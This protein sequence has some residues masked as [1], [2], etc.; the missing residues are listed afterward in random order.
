MDTSRALPAMSPGARR[1]SGARGADRASIGLFVV[2]AYGLSWAWLVPLALTGREVAAGSGWPTQVPALFGPMVAAFVASSR[3][4][5]RAAVGDLVRRMLRTRVPSR[6][7]VFAISPLLLL[8]VVLL[9]EGVSGH[10]LPQPGDF[11]R[12]SGLPAGWGVLGVAGALLV[13]GLGE[14]TGWRGYALPVLQGRY[15]ALAAT[16]VVAVMWI[17]WHAPMFVV[18]ETYRSFN[19]GILLGWCMDMYCGA[20][21]LTW[22]YNRSGASVLVVAVW[23][24]GYN[25]LSGTH[26][27]TGVLAVVSTA[28]VI[29]LALSLIALE[30][31]ATRRHRPSVLGPPQPRPTHSI[32][33]R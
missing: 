14:E 22:L 24:A 1:G 2:L 30:L 6:W 19:V 31:R 17:M 21:V 28:P 27:A 11:A 32:N 4:G 12:F 33:G 25:L 23:H 20:V 8:G 13:M 29:A 9:V 10:P 18:V 16:A 26:A 3:W 15:G 7:W 5:G